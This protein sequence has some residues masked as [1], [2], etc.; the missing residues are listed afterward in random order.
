MRTLLFAAATLAALCLAG[1]AAA[2]DPPA[3]GKDPGADLP[4]APPGVTDL[5]RVTPG[6]TYFNRPGATFEGQQADLKYCAAIAVQGVQPREVM[7]VGGGLLG[8]LI[9]IQIMKMEIRRGNAANIENCMVVR[10]WRVVAVGPEEGEKL[11]K[12]DQASLSEQLKLWVGADP[13]HGSV[14]RQ[15]DNEMTKGKTLKFREA[16]PVEHQSFSVLAL[17]KDLDAPATRAPGYPPAPPTA[18]APRP[19]AADK[20]AAVKLQPNE[21]LVVVSLRHVGMHAG[22]IV[23]LERMGPDADTPA[24]FTDQKPY[25]VDAVSGLFFSDSDRAFVVPA[26]TWRLSA[27]GE[28]YYGVSYCLGAPAF[29]VKPGEVVFAGTFDLGG[30]DVGPNLDLAPARTLMAKAPAE[31]QAKLAPAAWT[32]GY[33]AHCHGTYFYAYEIK[34]APTKAGYVRGDAPLEKPK[35]EAK[36]GGPSAVAPKP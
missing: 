8:A 13:V 9:S 11:A 22:I 31:L 20:M 14:V 16:G 10:G 33:T 23:A 36:V 30:E 32:N 27:V 6:Y 21:A 2:E 3:K 19:I 12:L 18:A 26:G 4:P 5:S 1:V 28:A 25:L 15:W 7:P 17:D 29:E 34:G 35:A 24:W